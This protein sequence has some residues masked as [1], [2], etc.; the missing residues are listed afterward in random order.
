MHAVLKT[1]KRSPSLTTMWS[2]TLEYFPS[3]ENHFSDKT[4]D[5]EIEARIRFLVAAEC[6]FVH[7]EIDEIIKRKGTCTYADIGDSDGS[8]RVVM[9]SIFKKP[10]LSTVGI[11][12]QQKVVDRMKNAGMNAICGD[13]SEIGDKGE[14][15]NI[16]SLFETM[17]HLPDPIGFLKKIS[18]VVEDRLVI[19]VPYLR[20]SRVG[21]QYTEGQWPVD[22][23]V[24]VETVHIFELCPEDWNKIFRHSGWKIERQSIVKMFPEGGY[25]DFIL[26]KYWRMMSFE[27]FYFVSLKKDQT[28]SSKYRVE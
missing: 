24:T 28:I 7:Q 20:K 21:L 13:A 4:L 2:K 22:R 10:V 1:V 19:S 17:E 26:G 5:K 23:A 16:V 27:G 9:E 8:V 18:S 14:R 3:F 12:L 25:L 11:N 15:F 6:A